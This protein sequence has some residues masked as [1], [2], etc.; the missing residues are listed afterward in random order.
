MDASGVILSFLF[1]AARTIRRRQFAFVNQILDAFVAINA[2]ELG[3][4]GF[5][6]TVRWKYQRNDFIADGACGF[7][8]EMAIETI[9]VREFIRCVGRGLRQPTEEREEKKSFL[10]MTLRSPRR[11]PI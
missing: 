5:I 7:R 11:A 2:I 9:A 3:V 1:V 10:P 4:D 6:E 8:I